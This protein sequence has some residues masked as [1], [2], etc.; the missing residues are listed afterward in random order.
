M[1]RYQEITVLYVSPD[2][3]GD[4]YSQVRPLSGLNA[5]FWV[6]E[7]MRGG[8]M[9]QPIVIRMMGG[10]YTMSSPLTI[11]NPVYSVTVEPYDESPVIISGGK[12][13]TGFVPSVFNGVPCYAAYIEEV[14]NG[15]IELHRS[16]GRIPK[17]Y[18]S[19]HIRKQRRVFCRLS[20]I[21]GP[22][23]VG[24]GLPPY[25]GRS[26]ERNSSSSIHR[27]ARTENFTQAAYGHH[28]FGLY[29]HDLVG[30]YLRCHLQ[31]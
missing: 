18:G 14:K 10:E 28:P 12:K 21:I 20:R 4:G 15:P 26:G 7:E 19:I 16:D 2:G 22:V 25:Y 5:A 17:H 27:K 3:K 30:P 13:I 29:S 9:L 24:A 8:G 31:R 11:S 23:G 1:R 6:V